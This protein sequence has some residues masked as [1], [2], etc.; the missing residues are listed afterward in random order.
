MLV[1]VLAM[2]NG[3]AQTL[4]ATGH[5]NRAIVLRDGAATES[6]SA[7]TLEAVQAIDNAPGVSSAPDGERRVSREVVL[8]VTVPRASG[9]PGAVIARGLT[10]DGLGVR[11]GIDIVG[12]RVFAT[13]RFEVIVGAMVQE[14]FLDMRLGE[15]VPF[16]GAD[17]KIVGIFES[18]GDAHESE[19]WGDAATMMSAADRQVF[20]AVT[21]ELS[22][23]DLLDEFALALEG[24][25]R[26]KVSVQREIDYYAQRSN[27]VSQLLFLVAYVVGAIMALGALFAAL[28]T[29]Y[30]SVSARTIEIATLRALGFGPV[31]VVVSVLIESLVLCVFGALA[32]AGLAWVLLNGDGFVSGSEIQ[33]IAL[34]LDIGAE[35][36][37]V[38]IAWACVIGLLGGLLPAIRAARIPIVEGLRV[39]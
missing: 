3:L 20:N 31:P 38:A 33:M 39:A 32:G 8:N 14:Q 17:W 29:M 15:S 24:D 18:G 34:R 9:A 19:I 26:L 12:G 7:V 10:G 30:S 25:P 28:N 1:S 35:L 36:F 22:A 6:L 13:G 5:P 27:A 23:Q 21:V 4:S 37:V 16:H 11:R 2:A